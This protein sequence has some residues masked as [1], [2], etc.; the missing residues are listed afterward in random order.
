[1][2][3]N[4]SQENVSSTKQTEIYKDIFKPENI[5]SLYKLI[6]IKIILSRTAQTAKNSFQSA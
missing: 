2:K 6:Y 5:F 1:M 4:H 3:A